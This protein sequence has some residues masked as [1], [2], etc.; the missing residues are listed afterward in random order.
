VA[1]FLLIEF[2]IE[3]LY[4]FLNDQINIP[5]N[6]F[7]F[8]TFVYEILAWVLIAIIIYYMVVS[9]TATIINSNRIDK[10]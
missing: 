10:I 4:Y 6:L 7:V 2:I 5:D 8:A 9:I 3:I 1:F